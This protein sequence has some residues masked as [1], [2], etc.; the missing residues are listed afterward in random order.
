MALQNPKVR[1][2]IKKVAIKSYKKAKP[3]FEKNIEVAKKTSNQTSPFKNFKSFKKKYRENF[4]NYDWGNSSPR[5]ERVKI[6]QPSDVTPM[7]CSNWADKLLSLVTAVHPSD[8][9][10]TSC[11]PEF[12]MGS[13]VKNI[14]SSRINPDLGSP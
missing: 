3:I 10:F 11:Y 14:P 6:S 7:L 13:I 12:I 5:G 4:K 1:E 9:I 8:N 2:G